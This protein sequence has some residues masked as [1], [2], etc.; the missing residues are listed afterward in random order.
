MVPTSEWMAQKFNIFNKKYFNGLLEQPK[1]IVG[2]PSG[3]WGYLTYKADFNRITR[4]IGKR[5]E[6]PELM[7]TNKYDRT[8]KDVSNTLI[9][10]MIHLYIYSILKKYPIRQHGNEFQQ[11]ANKINADGWEISETNELKPTDVARPVTNNTRN[12]QNINQ[13]QQNGQ[14]QQNMAQ[15]QQNTMSRHVVNSKQQNPYNILVGQLDSM[16]QNYNFKNKDVVSAIDILKDELAAEFNIN[17]KNNS[18]S[19][20]NEMKNINK[21]IYKALRQSLTEHFS[22]VKT[23]EKIFKTKSGKKCVVKIELNNNGDG[24]YEF[25]Y[26]TSYLEGKLTIENNKL[27]DYDGCFDL[28]NPVI[29]TLEEMNIIV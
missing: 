11:L 28:P 9:H 23:K 27:I 24:W 22:K 10:E 20:I 15:G 3:Y 26:G 21:L 5:H 7:L 17:N 4:K 8:V 19:N 18:I 2:C 29:K 13:N 25:E 14:S 16:F 6:V 12:K 1:F